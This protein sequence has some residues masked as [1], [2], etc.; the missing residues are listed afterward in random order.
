MMTHMKE[1]IESDNDE[2]NKLREQQEQS[3]RDEVKDQ[4]AD[5]NKNKVS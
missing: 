4:L 5:I 1:I 3:M 2:K